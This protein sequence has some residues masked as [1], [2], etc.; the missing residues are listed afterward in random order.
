MSK[1]SFMAFN[2]KDN[3]RHASATSSFQEEKIKFETYFTR[4]NVNW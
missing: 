1:M 3:S 4:V 2:S